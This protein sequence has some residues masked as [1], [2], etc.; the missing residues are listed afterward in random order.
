MLRLVVHASAFLPVRM[1][2]GRPSLLNRLL[3]KDCVATT[4][5]GIELANLLRRASSKR[6]L[7][8]P[9]LPHINT[10]ASFGGPAPVIQFLRPGQYDAPHL[11]SFLT[12]AVGAHSPVERDAL[13][14]RYFRA[15][16]QFGHDGV[17]DYT[18]DRGTLPLYA[19]AE[20]RAT[21]RAEL[22]SVARLLEEVSV[23]HSVA[24]ED[25][26]SRL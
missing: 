14:E 24:Q 1:R 18:S 26:Q 20:E 4:P 3:I 16:P 21:A 19:S 15:R 8:T 9:F 22:E 11:G 25:S 7:F 17:P 10:D 5:V 2:P 23:N 6:K 12:A 13:V